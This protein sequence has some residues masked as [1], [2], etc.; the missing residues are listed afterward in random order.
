[1]IFTTCLLYR[2]SPLVDS[3]SSTPPPILSVN[4]LTPIP[5]ITEYDPLFSIRE[6]VS[7]ELPSRRPR[8]P[9]QTDFISA[10]PLR[11]PVSADRRILQWITPH[12]YH[13]QSTLDA[14]IPFILQKKLLSKILLSVTDE[15]RM[16]YGAGLLRF[17]QFQLLHFGCVVVWV[18]CSQS[19]IH[20]SIR[21]PTQAEHVACLSILLTADVSF[22]STSLR[23]K[24][25]ASV[26]SIALSLLLEMNSVLFGLSRTTW[27]LTGSCHRILVHSF[28]YL[29][30]E[31]MENGFLLT[32]I[33]FLTITS[34]IFTAAGLESVHGHSYQIGG[35]LH[36][37][38]DG[39]SPEVIMKIGGWTSL[40]FLIYWCRLE[41]VIPLAITQTWD[42]KV[43]E[44]ARKFRLAN[45]VHDNMLN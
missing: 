19:Q 37:L 15:S 31:R 39:V 29:R 26:G 4:S 21:Q 27:M 16:T 25:P 8:T 35:T 23:P 7:N 5:Y 32:K 2:Y 30:I 18:N 9:R 28:H 11:P 33:S 20:C 34:N 14:E 45:D 12:S 6:L 41:Q 17:N 1:M 10:S 42:S 24:P 22:L 3:T 36:L 43:K 38:L 13:A 40:C 44:F